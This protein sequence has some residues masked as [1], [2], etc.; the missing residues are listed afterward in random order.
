ML[1]FQKKTARKTGR[2]AA[3]CQTRRPVRRTERPEEAAL[4]PED[5]RIRYRPRL[6]AAHGRVPGGALPLSLPA[7]RA[8]VPTVQCC[9]SDSEDEYK[10]P[11]EQKAPSAR[12]KYV[13]STPSKSSKIGKAVQDRMIADESDDD[14]TIVMEDPSEKGSAFLVTNYTDD[15]FSLDDP[16]DATHVDMGHLYPAVRFW[17]EIGRYTGAQS[18]CVRAFMRD[19]NN[20]RLQ[21][22]ARNC[23]TAPREQ[24]LPVAS[25]TDPAFAYIPCRSVGDTANFDEM[26]ARL[27]AAGLRT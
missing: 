9:G 8:A 18:D 16:A 23:A 20:Y 6:P 5:V 13:G 27:K 11:W 12:S 24:Y 2:P 3:P 14:E 1:Q 10:P 15:I 21:Y 7:A 26:I 17:N 4:S 19:P 22:G 25:K